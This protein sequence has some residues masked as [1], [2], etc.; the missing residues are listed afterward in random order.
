MSLHICV[1]KGLLS[2]Q[3]VPDLYV[4]GSALVGRITDVLS[5]VCI[6]Y[7]MSLSNL[8]YI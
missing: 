8:G 5:F 6:S 7:D 3:N 2:Y 4:V 1:V